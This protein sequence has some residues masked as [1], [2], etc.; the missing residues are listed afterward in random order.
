MTII[1]K[2]S[3]TLIT[4]VAVFG[5][6]ACSGDKAETAGEKVDE[7]VHDAGNAMEDA[8]DKVDDMANDTGNAIEDACEKV[9]EGV[10]AEDT[11]C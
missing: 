11:D 8:G 2:L 5:L 9:K 10:K 1:K 3:T 6:S 4:F 7:M